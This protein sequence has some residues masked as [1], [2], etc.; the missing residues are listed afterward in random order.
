VSGS[1]AEEIGDQRSSGIPHEDE[2]T[3]EWSS[4]E[5]AVAEQSCMTDVVLWHHLQYTVPI[6]GGADGR[7]LDAVWGYVTFGKLTSDGRVGCGEREWPCGGAVA[8]C[9]LSRLCLADDAAQ[10]VCSTGEHGSGD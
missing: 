2:K 5:R 10:C 9:G 6:S 7:L 3:R 4:A 1:A 8:F